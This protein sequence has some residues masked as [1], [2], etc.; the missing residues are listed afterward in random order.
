MPLFTYRSMR[1]EERLS[2]EE[3]EQEPDQKERRRPRRRLLRSFRWGVIGTTAALLGAFVCVVLAIS[4]ISIKIFSHPEPEITGQTIKNSFEDLAELAVE[5]YRF[6]GVGK[7]SDEGRQILGWSVPFT[8]KSF[9]VTYS[10]TIKAGISDIEKIDVNI[11]DGAR[12]VVLVVPEP[13]VLSSAIDPASIEQYDQTFNPINQ[14]SVSD[15]TDFLNTETKRATSEALA[16]GLLERA[17]KRSEELLSI[18]AKSMLAGT[19]AADYQ[20]EVRWNTTP[21]K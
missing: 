19:Q 2:R 15:I 9:L 4:G 14:F 3:S 10:G 11:D 16:G 20:I 12:K 21:K 5:E 18:Q 13:Q 8:G 6:T 7:F 1:D 17:Q